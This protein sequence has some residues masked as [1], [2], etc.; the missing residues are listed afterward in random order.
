MFMLTNIST[1]TSSELVKE[2]LQLINHQ[3]AL[4]VYYGKS[5]AFGITKNIISLLWQKYSFWY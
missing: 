2:Y 1:A 3:V 5:A 4:Q